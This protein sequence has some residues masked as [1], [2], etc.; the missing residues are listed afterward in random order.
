MKKK[1]I[2]FMA[3]MITFT[4]FLT[5]CSNGGKENETD[6]KILK[7]AANTGITGELAKMGQGI[8]DT[9]NMAFEDIDYKI[10]DYTIELVWVDTTSDPE[11][12]ALA[13]EQAIVR[14]KVDISAFGL[15]TSVSMSIMDVVS[16]YEIPHFYD[17]GAGTAIDE[18]WQTD[19]E[20]Y[21]YYIGKTW[22]PI[23]F[24]T[25]LYLDL[26]NSL[27]ADGTWRPSVKNISIIG[28]DNDWG[29]S[30]G[31]AFREVFE[32]GGWEVVSEDFFAAGVTDFYA[33]LSKI[34]N[35]GAT[36]VAGTISSGPSASAF[37]K[38]ARELGLES[39]IILD[40]LSEYGNWYELSGEAANGVIDARPIFYNEAGFEFAERF[41]DK[42][43]YVASS[44]IEGVHWDHANNLIETLRQTLDIYGELTTESLT[45]FGKNYVLTGEYEFTD[46]ITQQCF[47]WTPET[48]P[49]PVMGEDYF[50]AS[51]MQMWDGEMISIWP[52]SRK[53]GDFVL[54]DYLD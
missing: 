35:S 41:L 32:G 31:R 27:E 26:I 42:Y 28:D 1:I 40:G 2:T 30:V 5:A 43:G 9:V 17:N 51:V 3:L 12:G 38:Q 36:V 16:K 44:A 52:A 45:E 21:S 14:D 20:K 39:L 8:M 6:N 33:I 37:I 48:N 34:K 47:K 13:I 11:K 18:K 54:P 46:G 23:D 19:P 7:I 4:L 22:A 49:S 53:V 24:L 25:D 29:R 10:G 50:Y 15:L